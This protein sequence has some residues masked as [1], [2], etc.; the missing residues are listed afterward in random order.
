VEALPG[1][2]QLIEQ[3]GRAQLAAGELNQAAATFGRLAA[4]QAQLASGPIGQAEVA[5]ARKDFETAARLARRALELEPRSLEAMRVAIVANT[6]LKR[7]DDALAVARSLQA[8]WPDEALGFILEGEIEWSR[9]RWDAAAQAFR[10][11]TTKPSPA[12]SPGRLHATLAKAGKTADAARL[13]ESWLAGH[14]KDTLFMLYLADAA[15]RVDD[16]AGAERR[17]RQVLAVEA[18]NPMALNNLAV[19][20]IGQNRPGALELAERAV[21][22][23]P[24]RSALQNTLASALAQAGQMTQAIEVQ[25][26]VVATLPEVP[27]YRLHLARLYLQA[28]D[29]SAAITELK[30]LGAIDKPFPGREEL[31]ELLRRA[32]G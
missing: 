13:A 5:L 11:A 18:E 32:G 6:S 20:L 23:A 22:A 12:Q 4:Q 26:K 30:R 21:K 24:G 8:Q 10:A 28:G 31:P 19:L 29:K 27:D 17:Y 16:R 9:E 15:G 2:P 14:P 3:L 25:K 7:H 1:H